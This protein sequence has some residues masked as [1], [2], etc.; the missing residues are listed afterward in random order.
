MKKWAQIIS[1]VATLAVSASI[2]T[3]T[4]LVQDGGF[5][6]GLAP[7]GYWE[8]SGDVSIASGS[9]SPFLNGNYALLGGATNSGIS[10]LWQD[11][12]VAPEVDKLTVKFSAVFS[13]YDS[14]KPDDVARADLFDWVSFNRNNGTIGTR[15][16]LL[17][18]VWSN[19]SPDNGTF[20]WSTVV[21]ATVDLD[22]ARLDVDPNTRIRFQLKEDADTGNN[23]KL[24][25]D[26]V[27]V[28]VPE[29][30]T[31]ALLGTGL[32]GLTGLGIRRKPS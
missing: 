7:G 21:M 31:L 12:Y 6:L 28:N 20:T 10:R 17:E 8:Y 29:P 32:L 13:G 11:F 19:R 24:C 25:I 23:T 2:A 1:A 26:N 22:D 30:G 9:S 3:A 27:A 5:D 16:E 18:T 14:V 4:P 15:W